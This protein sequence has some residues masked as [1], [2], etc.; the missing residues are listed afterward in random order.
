MEQALINVRL[1]NLENFSTTVIVMFAVLLVTLVV[2]WAPQTA[3][4]ASLE[5]FSQ[6]ELAIQ[7]AN[8]L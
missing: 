2:S 5:N 7:L 8:L 1:V 6:Q 4:L 3:K